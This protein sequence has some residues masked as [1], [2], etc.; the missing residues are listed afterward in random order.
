MPVSRLEQWARGLIKAAVTFDHRMAIL[1][2]LEGNQPPPTFGVGNWQ[3]DEATHGPRIVIPGADVRPRPSHE[4]G[5]DCGGPGD[6]SD[7]IVVPMADER[8]LKRATRATK[9]RGP[10]RRTPVMPDD[11]R[12]LTGEPIAEVIDEPPPAHPAP[13]AARPRPA[14]SPDGRRS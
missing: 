12:I 4:V 6:D 13:V 7:R 5:D 1:R 14:S 10:K 11:P 9:T 8:Y 2:F 3:P